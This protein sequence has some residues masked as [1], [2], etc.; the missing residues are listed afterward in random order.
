MKRR[1]LN[2]G[3]AALLA[4]PALSLGSLPARAQAAN[5]LRVRLDFSPWGM[6]AAMHLSLIHI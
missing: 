6:H 2:Q 3:L 4:L 1:H 5:K